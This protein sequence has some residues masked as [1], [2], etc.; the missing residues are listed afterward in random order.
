MQRRQFLGTAA[1]ATVGLA[2]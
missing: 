2:G 1:V